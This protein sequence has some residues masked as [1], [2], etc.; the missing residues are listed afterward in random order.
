MESIFF[1]LP[2]ALHSLLRTLPRTDLD[3]AK[4]GPCGVL[5]LTFRNNLADFTPQDNKPRNFTAPSPCH[6][7]PPPLPTTVCF[8]KI[9]SLVLKRISSYRSI[10]REGRIWHAGACR[11][12]ACRTCTRQDRLVR[13]EENGFLEHVPEGRFDEVGE[14]A[15]LNDA[16]AAGVREFFF[17]RHQLLPLRLRHSAEPHG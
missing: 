15:E 11:A 7:S 10:H 3:E 12:G 14:W 13:G 9:L 17:V 2:S 8:R 16:L 4:F 6:Y 5:V 1:F